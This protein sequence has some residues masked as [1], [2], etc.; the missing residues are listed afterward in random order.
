MPT[1]ASPASAEPGPGSIRAQLRAAR[2]AL[3]F[4]TRLPLSRTGE[5]ASGT[6][7]MA[8]GTIYFPLVGALVGAW[9][10]VVYWL[11]SAIWPASVAVV[12]SIAATVAV[13]GALHEDGLA[14]AVDGFGGGWDRERILAIMRDS[15]IGAYGA[16]AVVLVVLAKVAA[17]SALPRLDVVRALIAAHTLARWSSLPLFWRLPYAREAGGT[18]APFIGAVT[19]PR[20]LVG[21]ALALAVVVPV[22]GMHALWPAAAA[23]GLTLASGW[24]YARRIGG[25]TG[26]CLGATNQLVEVAT[27]LAVL[28]A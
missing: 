1:R 2:A 21:T 14:D 8:R 20:L 22:L 26:D 10:G 7:D 16:L 24:Y 28:V 23:L 15:R 12:L 9:G 27:Y 19:I 13:T 11:A 4:L 18:A 5:D 6:V 17:L 3:T 25:I